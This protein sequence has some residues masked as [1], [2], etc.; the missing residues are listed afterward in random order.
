LDYQLILIKI[1]TAL[2]VDIRAIICL[3]ADIVH[4]SSDKQT[5]NCLRLDLQACGAAAAAAAAAQ[6]SF[7]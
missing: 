6:P 2:G 5:Y 3:V 4:V 1:A 7:R